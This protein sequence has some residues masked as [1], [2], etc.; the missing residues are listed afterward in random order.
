MKKGIKFQ[1]D[2]LKNR[3]RI[4]KVR[5]QTDYFGIQAIL[6]TQK[7]WNGLKRHG[8]QKGSNYQK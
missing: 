6:L 7:K 3:V 2:I 8:N 4:I 5:E 1:I